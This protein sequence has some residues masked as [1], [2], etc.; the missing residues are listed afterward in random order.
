MAENKL[1]KLREFGQSL[2]LDNIS[3]EI[4]QS[5]YL[6]RLIDEDGFSGVTSNPTI[7]QRAMAS[8]SLYDADMAAYASA[9]LTTEQIFEKLAVADIQE[10][11]D[12]LRPVYDRELGQDG[13]ISM[14]V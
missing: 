9:G 14:E 12:L 3:R 10:G 6:K 1:L 4:L 5:G 8:G 2:W 7:F 13:F 11:A